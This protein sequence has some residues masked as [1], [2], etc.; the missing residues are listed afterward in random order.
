MN[1]QPFK[2]ERYFAKYEFSSP[3][4]LSC[5]D[6][7][8]LSLRE[9]LSLADGESM[10]YWNL[11]NLGY[12]ESQ[13]NPVLRQEI[14]TLYNGVNSDEIVIMAP[15]E[16]I[17]IAMNVLLTKGDEII[18]T[19]P[20]YQSL[21]AVAESIGCKIKKWQPKSDDSWH[22]N[23]EDLETMITSK[24]KLVI[25]NFP[26]NPTGTNISKEEQ[27]QLI[28][29]AE[30][31]E[32]IIFSDEMYRYLEYNEGDRLPSLIEKSDNT[33][34]L[35]GMSKSFGLAGL[36]TGWL[37]TKHKDWIEEFIRFKDYTTICNSAPSEVLALIGIRAKD[38]IIRNNLHLIEQNLQLL[39]Q[40]FKDYKGY[41][42]WKKPQAGTIAFP[43]I[44]IDMNVAEFCDRLN[45][46]QGVMLLPGDVYDFEG[47]HFR[48]GF[49]R[50]DFP[51][52]LSKLTEFIKNL[53]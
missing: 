31:N 33:I 21:Y 4:L 49:G 20:G 48:I 53:E 35:G 32:V 30:K 16:G 40:F 28:D 29:L 11:L 12:T 42:K 15:E 1:I 17:F 36:R 13:G 24:T 7:E 9:L 26:H 8:P 51:L 41:F 38:K 45:H 27:A 46:K 44:L 52:A 34:V 3:Y 6:C 5:S 39:N 23:I 10:K 50:K 19:Y 47:N 22:F 37:I 14:T 43:E 2:L 25:I 18:V